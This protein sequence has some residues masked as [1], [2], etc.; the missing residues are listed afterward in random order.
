VQRSALEVRVELT[1]LV[2]VEP[3]HLGP[4]EGVQPRAVS[5]AKRER[6][7]PG[8]MHQRRSTFATLMVLQM[9]VGFLGVKRIV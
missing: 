6:L 5:L 9:L 8:L 1:G 7:Q 4:L 2:R 3:R